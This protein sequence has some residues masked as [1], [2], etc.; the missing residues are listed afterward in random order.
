[1]IDKKYSN[2]RKVNVSGGILVLGPNGRDLYIDGA[3]PQ[4]EQIM[5]GEL[6]GPVAV[7][8]IPEGPAGAGNRLTIDELVYLFDELLIKT[9]VQLSDSEPKSKLMARR[10]KN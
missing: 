8:I 9:G 2:P 6:L 4:Y 7:E 3:H 10:G 1:M 5:S